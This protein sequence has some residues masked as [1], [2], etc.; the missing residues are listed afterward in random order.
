LGCVARW[1]WPGSRGRTSGGDARFDGRHQ[2][3]DGGGAFAAALDLRQQSASRRRRR[4][5]CSN[6]HAPTLVSSSPGWWA[7]VGLPPYWASPMPT[8]P[9]GGSG[10]GECTWTCSSNAP[11]PMGQLGLCCAA[12]CD[13][14]RC[15]SATNQARSAGHH[16]VSVDRVLTAG[17]CLVNGAGS[18]SLCMQRVSPSVADQLQS[19]CAIWD[20]ARPGACQTCDRVGEHCAVGT[21]RR[22]LVRRRHVHP[23]APDRSR[24]GPG[25]S[26]AVSV[27]QTRG[28]GYGIRLSGLSLHMAA[29]SF[30]ALRTRL[31]GL[32]RRGKYP[33]ILGTAQMSPNRQIHSSTDVPE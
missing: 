1:S 17:T 15:C 29:L 28:A 21:G 10:A 32:F 16:V 26:E 9:T 31:P 33:R 11:F 2:S 8:T 27:K 4:I 14:H 18:H 6:G 3:F 7:H 20:I 22:A 23:L 24:L 25:D 30:N 5:W 19:H 12:V 13:T